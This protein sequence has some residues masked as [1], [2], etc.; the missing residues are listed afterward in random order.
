MTSSLDASTIGI[1]F[2]RPCSHL[3]HSESQLDTSDVGQQMTM[4]LAILPPSSCPSSGCPL[5]SS[6]HSN[7]M[8]CNV[9]PRPISSARIAPYPSCSRRPLTHSNRNWTPSR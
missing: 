3:V 7:V 9:F 4:R 2:T 6:V 8:P 5:F 1:V